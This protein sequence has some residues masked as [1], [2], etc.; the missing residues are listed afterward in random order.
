MMHNQSIMHCNKQRTIVIINM[1][2]LSVSLNKD[3]IDRISLF[4]I[5]SSFKSEPLR[6]PHYFAQTK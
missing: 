4:K 2:S 6:E 3:N 5:P 1:H